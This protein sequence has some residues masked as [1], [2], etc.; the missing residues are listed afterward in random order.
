LE[1]HHCNEAFELLRR[2]DC[3]ILINL[4]SEQYKI[5]RKYIIA[6]ILAT[7]LAVHGEFMQRLRAK[8]DSIKWDSFDDKKL[9]MCCLVKCA[10]I[11]NEIRP[12]EIG[13]NWAERVMTEFFAQSA[14]ER[15]KRMPVAPHMDPEQ[16]NTASGQIGFISYLAI[17]LFEEM[18]RLFPKMV[19]CCQQ[20]QSNKENWQK[21]EAKQK[22]VLIIV[23]SSKILFD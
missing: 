6:C 14:L 13:R 1:Q 15:E 2:P 12:S 9:I 23:N 19:V 16:T 4:D 3:N 22:E 10:D 18:A 8:S 7:D 5:A 17:P 11:S 20:M 21:I